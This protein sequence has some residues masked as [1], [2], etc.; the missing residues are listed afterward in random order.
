MA[1]VSMDEYVELLGKSGLMSEDEIDSARS[2]FVQQRGTRRVDVVDFAKS[3]EQKNILSGWHNQKLLEKKY[4]GFFLGS[5]KFL[6]KIGE[7][8]MGKVYLAEHTALDRR[9]AIKVLPRSLMKD[10]SHLERFRLEARALAQLDHKNIVRIYDIGEERGVPYIVMEYVEGRNLDALVAEQGPQT[11]ARA[12]H[13]IGQ[14]AAGLAHAHSRN[15]IHRDVK[16]SNLLLDRSNTVKL[17]DLGLARLTDD[18][19]SLT[20]QFSEQTLGTTDYIAPEQAMDS[21]SAD[22][23]SDIYSLGCTLYFLLTGHPPFNQ[24]NIAARLLAHQTKEPPSIR[25]ERVKLGVEPVDADMISL[26]SKMMQKE[27]DDRYQTA[28]DVFDAVS[29]WLKSRRSNAKASKSHISAVRALEAS[30]AGT[31]GQV[32]LTGSGIGDG[33]AA[34]AQDPLFADDWVAHDTNA[35]QAATPTTIDTPGV[36]PSDIYSASSVYSQTSVPSVGMQ[37]QLMRSAT[38]KPRKLFQEYQWAWIAGG[39]VLT[40]LVIGGAVLMLSGGDSEDSAA[41]GGARV[42]ASQDSNSNAA[43]SA[44]PSATKSQGDNG[45]TSSLGPQQLAIA[46]RLLVSLYADRLREQDVLWRNQGEL[47]EGFSIQEGREIKI[48]KSGLADSQAIQ[49]DNDFYVGP[50]AP[51]EITGGSARSIEVWA[52]NSE[53]SAREVM[54]SWGRLPKRGEATV[55]SALSFGYGTEKWRSA[56]EHGANT[57]LSWFPKKNIAAGQANAPQA[58]MWHYLA[59]T[60]GGTKESGGTGQARV[61]VDGKQTNQRIA[62]LDTTAD[63]RILLGAAPGIVGQ[64]SIA[65]PRRASIALAV[66]RVHSEA[67]TAKQ[68]A[69]NYRVD[70]ARFGHDAE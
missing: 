27:P 32:D 63:T 6:R 17:L 60:Y 68:V 21:H 36:A 45:S 4:K 38:P 20:R 15:L 25:D 10:T 46:G 34:P 1:A 26:C 66:V 11:A 14:A 49:L 8:G 41:G 53:M 19:T 52:F 54:V 9:C 64:K 5:Y 18:E 44:A 13:F 2:E 28:R 30:E 35:S 70:A 7:G 24:G 65:T 31:V 47:G 16:P 12:G 3:L 23:R 48:D 42:A 29:D 39:V 67:L 58:G 51:P 59:Y 43:V 62:E 33:D 61:F 37:S 69:Q 56:V 22:V 40:L 57:N 50:V 55:A